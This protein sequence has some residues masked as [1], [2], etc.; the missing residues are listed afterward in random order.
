MSSFNN[1]DHLRELLLEIYNDTD[2]YVKK[3]W[4]SRQYYRREEEKLLYFACTSLISIIAITGVLG[5]FKQLSQPQF[6]IIHIVTFH[7]LFL[8]L[9]IFYLYKQ[10]NAD[11]YHIVAIEGEK[12]IQTHLRNYETKI[13][14][15]ASLKGVYLNNK[16]NLHGKSLLT[17]GN[18]LSVLLYCGMS[19]FPFTDSFYRIEGGTTLKDEAVIS[20]ITFLLFIGSGLFYKRKQKSRI[21]ER[22]HG[23]WEKESE[24]FEKFIQNPTGK[25]KFNFTVATFSLTESDR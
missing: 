5:L 6:S 11:I 8:I 18:V 13:P 24:R 16:T 10:L 19:I 15:F 12:F 17:L 25:Y 22:V 7:A 23:D 14:T 21:A 9:F 1:N 3:C 20:L 4:A 2:E